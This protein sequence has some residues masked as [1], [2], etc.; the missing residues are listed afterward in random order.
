MREV[1]APYDA[2][3]WLIVA[4]YLTAEPRHFFKVKDLGLC[5]IIDILFFRFKVN[6][7]DEEVI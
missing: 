3:Q 6:R 7:K 1:Y 2:L 5:R 4:E